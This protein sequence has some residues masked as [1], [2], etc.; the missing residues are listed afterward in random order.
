MNWQEF[1][2]GL[3]NRVGQHETPLDTE[4]LWNKIRPKK[5]RRLLFFWWWLAGIGLLGGLV[6]MWLHRTQPAPAAASD[7]ADMNMQT[8]QVERRQENAPA[9]DLKTTAGGQKESIHDT[10]AAISP[11]DPQQNKPANR[12]LPTRFSKG[13]SITTA[14]PVPT[15]STVTNRAILTNASTS[16]GI[17]KSVKLNLNEN[18]DNQEVTISFPAFPAVTT[19]PVAPGNVS[20]TRSKNLY[21]LANLIVEVPAQPSAPIEKNTFEI[22]VQSGISCWSQYSPL[23]E[24]HPIGEQQRPLEAFH[25]GLFVQKPIRQRWAV[26]ASIRYQQFNS[27]F[28]WKTSWEVADADQKVLNYYTNGDVDTT[29]LPG[30]LIE[31]T[32]TVRHYNRIMVFTI[33]IDIKYTLPSRRGV[34]QP[35]IGIEPNFFQFARGRTL[36]G[37]PSVPSYSHFEK[38]YT[39]SFGMSVR[40]GISTEWRLK[41]HFSLLLEPVGAFD[42]TPRGTEGSSER[43]MQLGL[44]VGI[45]FKK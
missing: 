37:I 45:V 6:G 22:G 13:A 1:E 21:K 39:R 42:L 30:A 20:H 28:N 33:P 43:F 15:L 16:T 40:A 36:Y 19:L 34:V 35:F 7:S 38:E 29:Y 8:A 9:I 4:A 14:L 23:V 5:R 17:E 26:R 25:A 12:T 44:N 32:R 18:T 10:D 24:E 11:V 27:V 2:D 3:K 31:R 41:N